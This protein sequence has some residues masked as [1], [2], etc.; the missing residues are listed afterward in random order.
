[1]PAA[2]K[3]TGALV[4]DVL[5][6]L[7]VMLIFRAYLLPDP[8]PTWL[9]IWRDTQ[10]WHFLGSRSV[11]A[12][13]GIVCL[14]AVVVV[15]AYYPLASKSGKLFGLWLTAAMWLSV[16]MVSMMASYHEP[17]LVR[18]Q[19]N[20]LL[21]YVCGLAAARLFRRLKPYLLV[22]TV[23][24]ALQCVIA[25][26]YQS[27][28]MHVF[29]SG[30]VARAGGTFGTPAVL[31]LIPLFMLP[32][33]LQDGFVAEGSGSSTL[34]MAC[35][36]V[37]FAALVLTWERTGFLAVLVALF[38]LVR[39]HVSTRNQ[40]FALALVLLLICG[41][42]WV[43]SNGP[44]NG[45]SS[46]HSITSRAA[47]L[48]MGIQTFGHNWLDGVGIGRLSVPVPVTFRGVTADVQMLEPYNQFVFWLDEMGILGGALF[49]LFA[50]SVYRAI[51]SARSPM[52]R[53]V[54]AVWIAVLVA[55]MFNTIFGASDSGCGNMLIGSLIGITLRLDE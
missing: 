5:S 8:I 45:R 51:G 3:R 53:G 44:V 39:K 6:A 38:W 19:A 37:M 10:T 25:I 47:L 15:A 2:W 40:R 16:N 28:G 11:L 4:A 9:D 52:A 42:F 34:A 30:T 55:G 12:A 35:A 46:A 29:I 54:A 43:R 18:R 17:Q 23:C 27:K 41:A 49:L 1:M 31:Y 13:A 14:L 48:E 20:V 22:L 21:G 24:G 26:Y 33:A 32:I 50:F 7:L 36:S